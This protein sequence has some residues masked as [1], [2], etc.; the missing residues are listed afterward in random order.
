[1]L[2]ELKLAVCEANLALV[3]QG[4]VT[5]TWGNASAA[6]REH[7]LIVI[8]PSGVSYESMSPEMMAVVDFEGRRVQGDLAPSVDTP[9]HIELYREFELVGGIAHTHSRYATCWAQACR[10]I[11]C[12]GTTHADYFRGDV[13]ITQP[14]NEHDLARHYE[15]AI[16]QT[17]VRCFDGRDPLECPAA[18]V[19]YHAPFTWGPTVE[20]AVENA[21]V[22]EEIARMA[23]YTLAISPNQAPLPTYLLDRHFFRKHGG[24]AYYGQRK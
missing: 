12:L 13:P 15:R 24:D 23:V 11:P 2:E 20:A 17:I 7:G 6:D 14:L 4:L 22:L 9:A 16:G 18:L 19:A 10:P 8:K 3:R 1:M 5:M 21:L